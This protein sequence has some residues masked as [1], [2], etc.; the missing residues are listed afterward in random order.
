MQ[1]AT[2][3]LRQIYSIDTSA[4]PW[5]E[6]FEAR[7]DHQH[8]VFYEPDPTYVPTP[9]SA[10]SPNRR[11][12]D[13][14]S[15]LSVTLWLYEG[16]WLGLDHHTPFEIGKLR[17]YTIVEAGNEQLRTDIKRAIQEILESERATPSR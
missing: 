9:Y 11:R 10:R 7:W 16:A 8:D 4:L 2:S 12:L 13:P 14:N 3:E 17:V 5:V 15:G 1:G 6:R